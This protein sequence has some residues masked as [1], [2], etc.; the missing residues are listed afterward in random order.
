MPALLPNLKICSTTPAVSATGFVF[1]IAEIAVYPPLTADWDPVRTVSESSLP[2][3]RRW[4]C[5]STK[6][7][8][9]IFPEPSIP[10]T[11]SLPLDFTID[12]ITP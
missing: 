3:S 10:S 9:R 8:I 6:P 1:A 12:L 7:G 11:L 5:R 2:G 4:V